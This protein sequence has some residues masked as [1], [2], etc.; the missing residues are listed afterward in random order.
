MHILLFILYCG[1]CSFGI[2]KIPFFRKSGIRPLF[3]LTLFG[4]HVL[5]GCLHN[6]IAWRFYPEH[7]DIWF[8][9]QLSFVERH[10][11]LHDTHLF[12]YYNSGWDMV[13]HNTITYIHI[14]LDCFS[15]DDLWINTLLFSFPVFL[16]ITALYRV[17]RRQFPGSPL[18]AATAFL[19]PSTLFWT[20]CI[21][22]EALLFMLLG[23]FFYWLDQGLAPKAA[24]HDRM[25]TAAG[26]SPAYATRP[27]LFAA[28]AFLAITFIRF[29]VAIT[30]IPALLIWLLTLRPP[31]RRQGWIIGGIFASL[32]LF[33]AV[34]QVSA[35]LLDSITAQQHSFM[36]LKG[37]SILYLPILNGT[38]VSLLGAVPAALRNGLV[39]P[40]PGSGG[41]HIYLLFA[42]ELLLLWAIAVIALLRRL[43]HQRSSGKLPD[44][45]RPFSRCCIG[46]ALIGMLQIGLI[47]PFAGAIIRYRSI[48][49]PFLVAPCLF[50]LRNWQPF[51][52]LNA[53]LSNAFPINYE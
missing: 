51:Q 18:S 45:A 13:S 35:R 34:P 33:L 48:Y 43:I 12:L 50:Y 8:Y 5:V 40:L 23:L 21:H 29:A 30:L 15:F 27:L 49:L 2:L 46:F 31:T 41:Q 3:L 11:L 4:L 14:I 17:F 39:E 28:C 24:R 22:R 44:A 42:V 1:F 20:A 38:W 32:L 37:N 25:L 7:G 53:W 6:V 10:R 19:L 9:F 52:T 36:V 26:P 47:I 16:G